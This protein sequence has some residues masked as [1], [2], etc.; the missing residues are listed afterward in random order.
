MRIE[1]TFFPVLNHVKPSALSGSPVSQLLLGG[2]SIA[3]ITATG[4]G[5]SA[6]AAAAGGELAE[7]AGDQLVGLGG[8]TFLGW[9]IMDGS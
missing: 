3:T 7:T 5:A 4:C 2:T 8:E 1:I 9:L 6:T